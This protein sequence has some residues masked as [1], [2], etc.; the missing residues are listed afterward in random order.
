MLQFPLQC[1]TV[2]PSAAG[3]LAGLGI[4]RRFIDSLVEIVHT[5]RTVQ[6]VSLLRTVHVRIHRLFLSALHI[7]R[8]ELVPIALHRTCMLGR[9]HAI[10]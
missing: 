7:Y 2:C 9:L 3:D 1:L 8:P 6:Y 5:V 10:L 4:L